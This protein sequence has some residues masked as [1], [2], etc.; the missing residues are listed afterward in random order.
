MKDRLLCLRL[1]KNKD[2]RFFG[3]F[4]VY[5]DEEP[6]L[7]EW[8]YFDLEDECVDIIHT[9]DNDRAKFFL[10]R[11]ETIYELFG[12]D[13]DKDLQEYISQAKQGLVVKKIIHLDDQEEAEDQ[14]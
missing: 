3:K 8:A 13:F 10:V 7:S 1:E 12:L 14:I 2:G 11:L 4:D 9:K 6:I 5:D